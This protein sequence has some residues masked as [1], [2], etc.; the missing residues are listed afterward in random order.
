MENRERTFPVNPF[1]CFYF[2]Y[3]LTKYTYIRS[4]GSE[5]KLSKP[6]VVLA[7]CLMYLIYEIDANFKFESNELF[8]ILWVNFNS[9]DN[10]QTPK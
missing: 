10:D 6:F 4:H 3:K 9:F 8:K 5:M 1:L 2:Q 7:N